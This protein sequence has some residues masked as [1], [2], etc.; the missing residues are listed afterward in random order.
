MAS[1]VRIGV[2]G[3]LR[4]EVGDTEVEIASPSQRRLLCRLTVDAGRPVSTG[5]L[6]DAIWGEAL[7]ED[8]ANALRYH[9]WKL[10]SLLAPHSAI[11]T[12]PGG[13]RLSVDA[14]SIDANAFGDAVARATGATDPAVGL[15]A[16]E[17]ALALW[18]GRPYADVE[19]AEFALPEIRRL[20]EARRLARSARARWLVETGDSAN[21][22]PELEALVG[23]YPY[24]EGLWS[25]LMRALY[26]EGRQTE[27]LRA[28]QRARK[29]LGDDIGIE[30]GPELRD[31]ESRVLRQ[32]PDLAGVRDVP[33]NLPASFTSFIGRSAEMD[34]VTD[35]LARRRL[36]SIVGHGGSGKTRL[37]VE[38]ARRLL[39]EYADGVWIVDLIRQRSGDDLYATI[40]RAVGLPLSDPDVTPEIEVLSYLR[41][42]GSLLILDNCEHLLD[43]IAD[44]VIRILEAGPAVTIVATSRSA[45]RVPGE[46]VYA[47]PALRLPDG[48]GSTEE[49]RRVSAVRLLLDRAHDAGED[50][51]TDE[52]VRLAA[53]LCKLVDGLP[54]AIELVASRTA[55]VGLADLVSQVERHLSAYGQ[56]RGSGNRH[57]TM[58][59]TIRWSYELMGPDERDILPWLAV[60]VGGFT[61]EAAVRLCTTSS[62]M[63]EDA[64][65]RA[66]DA[67][68]EQSMAVRTDASRYRL[69]EPVRLFGF[70]RLEESGLV[71]ASRTAHAEAF[72]SI[73]IEA[74]RNRIGPQRPVV[75][76]GLAAEAGNVRAALEWLE[77]SG[78]RL[79]LCE[80]VAALAPFWLGSSM[81]DVARRWATE[82]VP[83]PE[84]VDEATAAFVH[85]LLALDD[86]RCPV[87][88][89]EHSKM[90]LEHAEAAG[91]LVFGEVVLWLFSK[92]DVTGLTDALEPY[93]SED[94]LLRSRAVFE[95][96]DQP[97]ETVDA[98]NAWV[99]WH[100]FGEHPPFD[101]V[102]ET[103]RRARELARRS[104]YIDGYI[105]ATTGQIRA[106]MA[107]HPDGTYDGAAVMALFEEAVVAAEEG[108]DA[109]TE[110]DI[111]NQ[112]AWHLARTGAVAEAVPL[113]EELSAFATAQG[114]LFGSVVV[115]TALAWVLEDIDIS[116][117]RENMRLAVEFCIDRSVSRQIPWVVEVGARLV[118]K[119]G[120][121]ELAARLLGACEHERRVTANPMPAWDAATYAETIDLVAATVG[122]SFGA[123]RNE[124]SSI[125]FEDAV[126]LLV[127][128]IQD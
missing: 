112:W 33:T 58:E 4:V 73:V 60:F 88:R 43:E 12:T 97:W 11:E 50:L 78:E 28:Y 17:E 31:L 61:M 119:N 45:L 70:G 69:L 51:D 126:D 123:L 72:A 62:E 87:D 67:L 116:R 108:V 44:V 9:V 27:A 20:E 114:N 65:R 13:Y 22:L 41:R 2:A 14:D 35:A 64:L 110:F 38:T 6:A 23:E 115:H 18:R 8:P 96:H 42:R 128:A 80:M 5:A 107:L 68:V 94:L 10:R 125:S 127:A 59:S 77:S 100:L 66:V 105:Y 25:T 3:P 111:R 106:H 63:N 24:D 101:A 118:A 82:C 1:G 104:G 89:I 26:R 47:I 76:E 19:A 54:L 102:F 85:C 117:A 49:I 79:R 124:G 40:G 30:P 83:L 46:Y 15:A 98:M 90:S 121:P 95:A 32:A 56:Q 57:R 7:P 99:G 39:A 36:V 109:E 52:D 93:E 103:V 29:A 48:D 21:A 53:D 16:A 120:D 75:D 84:F 86:Q 81:H 55:T 37:A 92:E 122:E 34:E 74:A 91:D 71:R 113:F